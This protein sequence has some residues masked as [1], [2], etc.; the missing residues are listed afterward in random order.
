MVVD[1]VSGPVDFSR[2]SVA[3][4]L[5]LPDKHHRLVAIANNPTAVAR[6]FSECVNEVRPSLRQWLP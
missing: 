3:K 5:Q 6:W 2:A 1:L 4:A